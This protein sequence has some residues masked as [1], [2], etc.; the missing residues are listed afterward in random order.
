MYTINVLNG[1]KKWTISDIKFYFSKKKKYCLNINNSLFLFKK[2]HVE[3]N[4]LLKGKCVRIL[5]TN[6]SEENVL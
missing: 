2:Y 4:H 1:H 6:S 3:K 5:S